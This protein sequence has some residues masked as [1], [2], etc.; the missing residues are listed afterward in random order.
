[1]K[2]I[3]FFV[4][5]DWYFCSHRLELAKFAI[6]NGFEVTLITRVTNDV[7][8]IRDA[9]IHVIPV[10]IER[11]KLNFFSDLKLLIVLIQIYRKLKP[12]IVHHVAVKPVLYGSIAALFAKRKNIVN[13]L[14]GLGFVF[15]SNNLKAKLL[16]PIIKNAFRLLL[17]KK[18][19]RLIVQNKD[20]YSLFLNK[21]GIDECKIFLIKGA[22]VD[23]RFYKVLPEPSGKIVVTLLARMLIDKGVVEF[24]EA[25]KI[26]KDKGSNIEF[27]LVGDPDPLNPASLST[28][29]LNSWNDEGYIIWKG[30]ESD[31]SSVWAN[32][33]ISVLPSYREGLP[34]S[35]LESAAC[36]RAIVTT[37]VPGCREVVIDG[38]NGLLVPA[39]DSQALAEA[40]EKL[41]LDENMRKIMAVNGRRLIDDELSSDRVHE[42]TLSLYKEILNS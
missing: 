7:V 28:D 21:F 29:V 2:K 30:F 20:D 12:D 22:G 19:S 18:G 39:K 1:M 14:G 11:S 42:Q 5:E 35:L 15:S 13:A 16:R 34:K 6:K 31:I 17:G 24:V 8:K 40:I 32:S 25:A 27:H 9:G 4:S 23:N 33:H 41:A 10:K 36:G 37:D 26:C 3:L 38:V